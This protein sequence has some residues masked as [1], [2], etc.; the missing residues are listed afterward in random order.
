MERLTQDL[1]GQSHNGFYLNF[2]I[3]MN[4]GD[5]CGASAIKLHIF[6]G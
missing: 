3:I 5:M 4:F 1:G 2:G 6:V